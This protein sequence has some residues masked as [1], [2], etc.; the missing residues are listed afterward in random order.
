A[1]GRTGSSRSSPDG[2]V[3]P[4][5]RRGRRRDRGVRS[6]SVEPGSG[7]GRGQLADEG[8]GGSGGDGG[9]E[10][11]ARRRC[12]PQPAACRG[13]RLPAALAAGRQVGLSPVRPTSGRRPTCPGEV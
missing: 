6:R 11:C 7:G 13:T 12:E 1:S 4:A 5:A 9:G 10:G 3:G 2:G 8:R